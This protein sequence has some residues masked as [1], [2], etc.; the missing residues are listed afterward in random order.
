MKKCFEAI[1]KLDL[2]DDPK[3]QSFVK[4]MISS[5]GENVQLNK[6]INTKK[7]IEEWL[8]ELQEMMR[9]T[10]IRKMKIGRN[11]FTFCI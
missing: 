9:D 6:P 4:G 11:V 1:Y 2:G 8:K 3:L 10:L 7:E 5:E